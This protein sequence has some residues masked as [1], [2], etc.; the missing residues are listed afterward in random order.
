MLVRRYPDQ[1]ERLL[2]QRERRSDRYLWRWFRRPL[3][4][5][6]L[7]LLERKPDSG[8]RIHWFWRVQALEFFAGIR[9]AGGVPKPQPVRVVCYHAVADLSA[10]RRMAPYGVPEPTFRRQIAFLA[11]HFRFVDAD[12]FRRSLAGGGVPRRALFLTFDDCYVDLLDPGLPVLREVHAPALA[13]A[14]TSLTGKTSEWTADNGG[15]ALPLLDRDQLQTLERQEVAIGAHTRTHPKLNE[16][17][18]DEVAEEIR[19]S[20]ADIEALGLRKP[21]LLAYPYGAHDPDVMREAK[22]AGLAG[23]FTTRPG[24]AQPGG[25]PYGIPRIEI[26]RDD[27]PLRFKW[28]VVTGR[29]GRRRR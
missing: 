16:L 10:S 11:K 20:I 15:V 9:E 22:E 4:E 12:E 7:A 14:V 3:R 27:G 21:S 13:F 8:R 1:A 26:L 5:L 29:R 24:I 2:S 28:K 25:D 23:A 17:P 19:G 6:A 18:P